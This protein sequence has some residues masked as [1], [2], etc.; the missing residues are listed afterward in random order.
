MTCGL[1]DFFVQE[2]R[3]LGTMVSF[4]QSWIVFGFRAGLEVSLDCREAEK[5]KKSQRMI[6]LVSPWSA[7]ASEGVLF[8]HIS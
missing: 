2:E 8:S 3:L 1:L 6:S 4:R 7:V 5:V